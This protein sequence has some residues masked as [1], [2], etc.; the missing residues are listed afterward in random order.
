MSNGSYNPDTH[1]KSKHLSQILF[2]EPLGQELPVHV[3]TLHSS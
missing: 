2:S 3:V 1:T